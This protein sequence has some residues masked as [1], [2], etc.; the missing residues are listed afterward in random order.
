MNT[1]YLAPCLNAQIIDYGFL[2]EEV[3]EG[4]DEEEEEGPGLLP[5]ARAQRMQVVAEEKKSS[6]PI[7]AVEVRY[8]FPVF[9]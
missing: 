5:Q 3:L 7:G 4:C 2:V 6:A 1:L 9:F 8:H